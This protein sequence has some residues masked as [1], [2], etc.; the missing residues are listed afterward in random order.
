M[1]DIENTTAAERDIIA[2]AMSPVMETILSA[3]RRQRVDKSHEKAKITRERNKAYQEARRAAFKAEKEKDRPLVMEALRA[4]LTDD[5]AT[6]E[7]RLF[8]VT[9]LDDM[10]GYNFI[11]YRL[12]HSSSKPTIR[13]ETKPGGADEGETK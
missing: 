12:K 8:A 13:A 5:K 9:A 3:G 6:A 2:N 7:Q 10:Q 11:P 1:I 4:I